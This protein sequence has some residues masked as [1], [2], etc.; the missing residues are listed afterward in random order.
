[1]F[2]ARETTCYWYIIVYSSWP[3]VSPSRYEAVFA[4]CPPKLLRVLL[5]RRN[6]PSTGRRNSALLHI[7]HPHYNLPK[8]CR[9]CEVQRRY[10]RLISNTT[11]LINTDPTPHI[12]REQE[13]NL[14]NSCISLL[15]TPLNKPTLSF[16]RSSGIFVLCLRIIKL[17]RREKASLFP[18]GQL[19]F[20]RCLRDAPVVTCNLISLANRRLH[21]RIRSSCR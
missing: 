16:C 6:A 13:R 15:S 20:G 14:E 2:H 1:M 21:T 8:Y 18:F 17:E 19:G 4:Y 5:Q 10:P 3:I 12:A 11:C 9:Y 7:V